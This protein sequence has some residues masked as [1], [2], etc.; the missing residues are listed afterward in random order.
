M[1]HQKLETMKRQEVIDNLK[2]E[3]DKLLEESNAK[4]NPLVADKLHNILGI[5]Y[6]ALER[7]AVYN[8]TK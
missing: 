5:G 4:T 3:L 1:E 8:G 2:K 6:K 7:D